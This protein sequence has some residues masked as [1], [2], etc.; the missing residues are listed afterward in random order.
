MKVGI[1]TQ[2][3]NKNYGGIMQNYALQCVLQ[4][5]GYEVE[6]LNWDSFRREHDHETIW[7]QFWHI[8]KTSISKF[9]FRRKRNYIWQQRSLFYNLCKTNKDFC[10]KH[11]NLSGWLWGEKQFREYTVANN[12][13][14]LV[15]GSDQTWR[16]K[17][18]NNGMLYR[19]FLDFAKDLPI[20]RIAYSASF[21]VDTWEYT[22]EE[23]Q[24]CS[25]LL[26]LFDSISVR[27]SSG[28]DLC[29]NHLRVNNVICTLD[30]TMLLLKQDYN[31]LL[32][33][34][35]TPHAEEGLMVYMLDYS[36]EKDKIVRTISYNNHLKCLLFIAKYCNL[37][38]VDQSEL[39]D[40]ILPPVD[41]WLSGFRDA[42]YVICDSFHGMVFSII[43]NKPFVVFSNQNRGRARFL[44]LLNQ[45]GLQD[46]I[47]EESSDDYQRILD[48]PID[49]KDVNNKLAK[50]RSVSIHYLENALRYERK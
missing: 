41:Y 33:C 39:V 34:I 32:D 9:I 23:T 27:E 8:I 6:T 31:K 25:Q 5:M 1:L 47:I 14:A 2:S 46:R 40:Y 26:K 36:E 3:I 43:Y 15:V 20:K 42:K 30:P 44:S 50:L 10:D 18:N 24:T 29:S 21:G 37:G 13:D 38:T 49:W 7:D 4:R 19:M 22:E 17:F 45:L 11:L 12:F 35:G 16:P 48:F 28:I